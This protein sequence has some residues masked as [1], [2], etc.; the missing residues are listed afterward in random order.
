MICS[1]CTPIE[2]ICCSETIVVGDAP[3]TLESYYIHIEDVSN[4]RKLIL[5]VVIS[6]GG[7][8]SIDVSEFNF[9]ETHSYEMYLTTVDDVSTIVPFEINGTEVDCL[10]VRFKKYFDN[11]NEVLFVTS[12]DIVLQ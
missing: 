8:M 12:Q 11:N 2:L 5:P 7:V 6:G 1:N 10:Q 9:A 4:G 3:N